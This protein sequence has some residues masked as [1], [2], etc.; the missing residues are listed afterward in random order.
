[1]AKSLRSK[2]ERKTRAIKREQIF[3]PVE[4]ARIMRLSEKIT[5]NKTSLLPMTAKENFVLEKAKGKNRRAKHIL[6]SV[7]GVSEKESKF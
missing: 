4:D 7:Y 5:L 6:P 1:M 2:R 3:K